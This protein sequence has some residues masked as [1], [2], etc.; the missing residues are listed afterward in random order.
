MV[1]NAATSDDLDLTKAINRGL[2]RGRK[3]GKQG[4]LVH[5]SGTQLIESSGGSGKWEEVPSYNVSVSCEREREQ[6][7]G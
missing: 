4:V 2:A 3:Q 5:V 1:I 7:R 6:E